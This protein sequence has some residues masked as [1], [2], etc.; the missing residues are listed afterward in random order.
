MRQQ[1]VNTYQVQPIPEPTPEPS[2]VK[3]DSAQQTQRRSAPD[4]FR[5]QISSLPVAQ[6]PIRSG[7]HTGT[8]RTAQNHRSDPV[9]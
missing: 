7:T 2:E 8:F 5:L 3:E 4:E 9:G 6:K 1:S